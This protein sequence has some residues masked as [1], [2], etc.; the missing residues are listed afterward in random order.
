MT[1]SDVL[2]DA[3]WVQAHLD[4][5]RVVPVEIDDGG[6]AYGRGHIKGAVRLDWKQ[7]LQDPVTHGFV[8]RADLAALLSQR[9]ISSDDTL[10]LYS[11]RNN[12]FAAYAYWYLKVYGHRSAWL[13]A[14]GRRQWEVDSRELVT[15]VPHRPATVYRTQRPERWLQRIIRARSRGARPRTRRWPRPGLSRRAPAA[16]PSPG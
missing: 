5:A 2:V 10:I 14:G 11:G 15:E 9:G 16:R 6:G 8:D 12:W 7:D 3:D 13:L 4:D 1:P